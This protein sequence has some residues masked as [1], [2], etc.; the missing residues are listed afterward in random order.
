[1]GLFIQD[2]LVIGGI[3]INNYTISSKGHHKQPIH[4]LSLEVRSSALIVVK[5][6]LMSSYT[7]LP[8]TGFAD[9][10]I[11]LCYYNQPIA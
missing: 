5:F 1:M 6:T 4:P 7:L 2:L 8:C 9:L 3:I 10:I 11:Q